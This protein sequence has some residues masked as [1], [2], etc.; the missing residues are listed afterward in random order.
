MPSERTLARARAARRQG[1]GSGGEAIWSGISVL[2]AIEIR[3]P[4]ASAG[5][6]EE[7]HHSRGGF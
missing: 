7:A 1:K 2:V 6:P 4:H 5:P 3:N